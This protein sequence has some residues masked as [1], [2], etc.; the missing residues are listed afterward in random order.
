M[1]L[2]YLFIQAII[3][4]FIASGCSKDDFTTTST[5]VYFGESNIVNL[6][7]SE[8]E[9]EVKASYPH[10][11]I[12]DYKEDGT[13]I[14]RDTISGDWYK[15]IRNNNGESL[16]IK[17]NENRGEKRSLIIRII[18]GNYN[19]HVALSQDGGIKY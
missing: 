8:Q 1:S 18:N 6:S 5:P 14:P 13:K 17:V 10:W 3:V 4:T 9:I 11:R 16:Y 19:T 15:L 12:I 2:R 7:S